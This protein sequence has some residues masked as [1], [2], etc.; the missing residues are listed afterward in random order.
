MMT[1]AVDRAPPCPPSSI[2][3]QWACALLE[4]QKKKS[5]KKSHGDAKN[6]QKRPFYGGAISWQFPSFMGH[7]R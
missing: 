5:K 2:D 4:G 3:R 6:G 1:A 7:P